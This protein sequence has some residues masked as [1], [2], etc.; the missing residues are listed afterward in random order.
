MPI[1]TPEE[2]LTPRGCSQLNVA[3]PLPHPVPLPAPPAVS[4]GGSVRGCICPSGPLPLDLHHNTLLP[5][6]YPR[7]PVISVHT[8]TPQP[9]VWEPMPSPGAH[10]QEGIVA[11][12][13]DYYTTIFALSTS[14][15]PQQWPQYQQTHEWYVSN[16]TCRSGPH[17]G[18]R[19]SSVAITVQ[20]D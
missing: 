15:T 16:K 18:P 9:A 11:G 4:S 8:L 17:T 20:Y 5:S 1:P 3:P 19:V 12:F 2:A 14:T 10:P 13:C 6:S 7:P